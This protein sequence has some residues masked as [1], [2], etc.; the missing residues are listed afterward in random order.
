MPYPDQTTEMRDLIQS[1]LVPR[2]VFQ[3][4]NEGRLDY[5]KCGFCEV[6]TVVDN[7]HP[8]ILFAKHATECR[9]GKVLGVVE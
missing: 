8:S 4:Y 3:G 9:L 5:F 6:K 7:S 2:I 1:E